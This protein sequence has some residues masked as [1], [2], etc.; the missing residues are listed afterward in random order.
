MPYRIGGSTKRPDSGFRKSN[1]SCCSTNSC[2]ANANDSVV[3][4]RKR[5]WIRSAGSPM[6]S[7]APAPAAPAIAS[8]T[9]KS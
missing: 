4:A 5:P 9:K 6:S 2:T 3:T 1:H 7:A 8:T